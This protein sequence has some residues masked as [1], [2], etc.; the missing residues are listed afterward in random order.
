[1]TKAKAF[2]IGLLTSFFIWGSV[3]LFL[4]VPDGFKKLERTW[5]VGIFSIPLLIVSFFVPAIIIGFVVGKNE[6]KYG[7][8]GAITGFLIVLLAFYSFG[9]LS[10]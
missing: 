3:W 10:N 2:F 5:M 9:P 4:S 1:M 8:Y 6:R 7:Y